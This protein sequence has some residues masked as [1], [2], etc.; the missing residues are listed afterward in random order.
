M[1]KTLMTSII[2][3]ILILIT[4]CNNNKMEKKILTKEVFNKGVSTY[5]DKD[6]NVEYLI[7]KGFR[8]GG[9]TPRLNSDG[10][11]KTCNKKI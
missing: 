7:F 8:A 2:L 11:I 9:I 6:Q 3:L 5:C 1:K 4:G 10:T